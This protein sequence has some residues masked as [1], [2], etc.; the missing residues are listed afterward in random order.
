MGEEVEDLEV[1]LRSLHSY[2]ASALRCTLALTWNLQDL[3]L[4]LPPATP[5]TALKG[6]FFPNLTL[7]DTNLPHSRLVEF[8]HTHPSISH[9]VLGKCGRSTGCPLDVNDLDG[10]DVLACPI[11]CAKA[12]VGPGVRDLTLHAQG[13]SVLASRIFESMPPRPNLFRLAVGVLPG[14]Y[15]LIRSLSC[16][17]PNLYSL[18]LLEDKELTAAVRVCFFSTHV[19]YCSALLRK[20][21][22]SAR[23]PWLHFSRWSAELRR[24]VFLRELSL[25]TARTLVAPCGGLTEE[26][27]LVARW[28]TGARSFHGPMSLPESNA[29]PALHH[30]GLWYGEI[31]AGGGVL[32]H[33]YRGHRGSWSRVV[34]VA[35]AVPGEVFF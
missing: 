24:L 1:S 8:L 33:W 10:V 11:Q 20:V 30:I 22:G 16:F 12:V 23:P 14:D 25:R 3:V 28:V 19:T 15:F 13:C 4:H 34:H 35:R 18:K 5:T 7:F 17:A 9:L 2:P 21:D 26:E 31:E 6:L 27:H 29:H 32:S